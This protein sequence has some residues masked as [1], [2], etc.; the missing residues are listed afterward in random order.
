MH[1]QTGHGSSGG[2]VGVDVVG[3]DVVGA[4]VV[5]HSGQGAHVGGGVGG[6]SGLSYSTKVTHCMKKYVFICC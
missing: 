2:V 3:A 6:R 1:V 4:D 5:G